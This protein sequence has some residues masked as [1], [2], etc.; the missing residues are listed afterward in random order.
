MNTKHITALLGLGQLSLDLRAADQ[1]VTRAKD[2]YHTAWRLFENDGEEPD[3]WEPA[4]RITRG[5][6]QWDDAIAATAPAYSAY[7]T[8]KKAARAVKRRWV[9][10]CARAAKEVG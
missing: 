3:D 10:A 7:Q 5:H 2:A 6:P 4:Q 1:A 9:A 8:A